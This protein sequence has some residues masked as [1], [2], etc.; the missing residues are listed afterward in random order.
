MWQNYKCNHVYGIQCCL[1][2]FLC[3]KI[4]N[5]IMFMEYNV[6]EEFDV[7]LKITNEFEFEEYKYPDINLTDGESKLIPPIGNRNML[8]D[9]NIVADHT[10]VLQL[11]Y[12]S[13]FKECVSKENDSDNKSGEKDKYHTFHYIFVMN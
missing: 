2:K 3:G 12:K 1:K 11:V 7:P 13:P 10:Y 9:I 8:S 4:I 5:V 6:V